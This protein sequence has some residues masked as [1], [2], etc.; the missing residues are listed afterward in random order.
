M[1][2]SRCEL[3]GIFFSFF[4]DYNEASSPEMTPVSPFLNMSN[5]VTTNEA[6][7][8]LA[9]FGI[10]KFNSAKFENSD[11]DSVLVRSPLNTE[12]TK[13]AFAAFCAAIPVEDAL[14]PSWDE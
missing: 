14:P 9:S 2:I 12:G 10:R 8:E 11:Q 4:L 1:L 13:K 7:R 5:T 3:G 6:E